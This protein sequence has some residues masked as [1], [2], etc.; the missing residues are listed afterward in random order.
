VLLREGEEAKW[1][2]RTA[3][4]EL[5]AMREGYG[6]ILKVGTAPL[7]D[8]PDGVQW[9]TFAGGAVNRFLAA[10]RSIPVV[11]RHFFA[12]PHVRAF[13]RGA[14]IEAFTKS[15]VTR[16]PIVPSAPIVLAAAFRSEDIG[17]LKHYQQSVNHSRA[18]LCYEA[19]QGAQRLF[20][21]RRPNDRVAREIH[22]D[23][24]SMGN[25]GEPIPLLLR[26]T[27]GPSPG[28][29]SALRPAGVRRSQ[30]PERGAVR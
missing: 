29:L 16:T 27:S 17:I 9:H 2:T 26:C 10:G 3:A 30:P 18:L 4:L 12:P 19:P 1:L 24:D 11:T 23:G 7:E 25:H 15:S 13:K 6:S 8:H 28:F 20:C 5:A 21:C 22:R 14:R